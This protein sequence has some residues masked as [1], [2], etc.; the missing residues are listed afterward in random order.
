MQNET[1]KAQIY[2]YDMQYQQNL[3]RLDKDANILPENKEAIKEFLEHCIASGNEISTAVIV[4]QHLRRVARLA[5]KPFKDFNE[6]DRDQLLAALESAKGGRKN[7][8]RFSSLNKSKCRSL[9]KRMMRDTLKLP[10]KI[11]QGIKVDRKANGSMQLLSEHL[12]TEDEMNAMVAAT[13]SPMYK[14]MLS[15]LFECGL[16]PGELLSIRIGDVKLAKEEKKAKLYV[17]GKME[18]R[19]GKRPVYVYRSLEAVKRWIAIH[20]LK[21]NP[22]APLWLNGNN[23]PIR[24]DTFTNE[25]K[26]LSSKARIAKHNFPYLARHTRLTQFYRDF[27]A[28][29]GAKLAGH[30]PGI[31]L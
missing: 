21:A 17:A 30:M 11:W 27:G 14:A 18:K 15:V 29:I 25:Y 16:R 2:R 22:E 28:V 6:K 7:K 4:I 8:K 9:L 24:L 26:R 31:Q 5:K 1:I 19:Q 3:Q 23:Q 10:D 13:S 20:P 12:L